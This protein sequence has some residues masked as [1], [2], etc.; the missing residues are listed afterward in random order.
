[1]RLS[2][3]S[4]RAQILSIGL[5]MAGRDGLLS[6]THERVAESA[7][8]SAAT[9]RRYY[10]T[11]DNLRSAIASQDGVPQSVVLDALSLGLR[12]ANRNG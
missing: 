6:V 7:D 8:V 4:R 3:S 1:M 11:A 12:I 9:V 5:A 10:H 2:G